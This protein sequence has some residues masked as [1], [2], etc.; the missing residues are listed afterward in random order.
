MERNRDR[1]R[2]NYGTKERKKDSKR[3]RERERERN[4]TTFDYFLAGR[5]CVAAATATGNREMQNAANAQSTGILLDLIVSS[6][7]C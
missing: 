6:F 3:E 4:W 2:H 5:R 1:P 7:F